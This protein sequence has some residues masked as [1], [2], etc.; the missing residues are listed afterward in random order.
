MAHARFDALV[1][2]AEDNVATA[3]RP[4]ASGEQARIKMPCGETRL[5]ICEA[6]PLC[7]KVALEQLLP[8]VAVIKY[9]APIGQLVRAAAPGALVHVHNLRTRR[10]RPA[11]ER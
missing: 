6:I 8:G 9:G 4:L 10:G 11:P 3:L 1:L 2:H 7:H 5:V